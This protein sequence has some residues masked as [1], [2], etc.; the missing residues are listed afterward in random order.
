[1]ITRM[2][3]DIGKL[4]DLLKS[5]NLDGRTVIMFAGDNGPCNAGGH[6]ATTFH[7]TPFRSEGPSLRGRRSRLLLR[8]LA[9]A[10]PGA[11]EILPAYCLLGRAAD[12][13]RVGGRR[14]HR[15]GGWAFVSPHA[16]G[17]ARGPE[18]A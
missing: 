16:A 5:L 11:A 4:I 2:D 14:G 3:R 18:T 15:P 12:L 1:M 8:P 13:R 6:T 9:R 17:P 10:H 7:S